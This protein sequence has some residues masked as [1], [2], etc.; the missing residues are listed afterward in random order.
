VTKMVTD[1]AAAMAA[2]RPKVII[3]AG[4]WWEYYM[5]QYEEVHTSLA[6]IDMEGRYHIDVVW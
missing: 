5:A 2:H 4:A 6:H 3:I 1:M